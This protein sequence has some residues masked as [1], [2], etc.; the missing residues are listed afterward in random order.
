MSCAPSLAYTPAQSTEPG[1][2][3]APKQYPAGTIDPACPV[4]D[5]P[6]DCVQSAF[7]G[8][9][10]CVR[11]TAIV[12]CG[13][14]QQ[15]RTRHITQFPQLG[16]K[17]CP[18]PHM[19]E[20]QPC[21]QNP[22]TVEVDCAYSLWTAW[23]GCDSCKGQ[24]SRSRTITQHPSEKGKACNASVALG[25]T[26]Q[27]VSSRHCANEVHYCN[28]QSWEQWS[29]CKFVAADPDQCGTGHTKRKR[30]MVHSRTPPVAPV[31]PAARLYETDVSA[32]TDDAEDEEDDKDRRLSTLAFAFAAGGA[33][34]GLCMVVL[35]LNQRTSGV[36]R[37]QYE[38]VSS[39]V[40]Q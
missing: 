3:P 39:D 27:C 8:W 40:S 30:I 20:T 29:S 14:G 36:D 37:Q 6:I 34:V 22:C 2:D 4:G 16:G 23:N 18:D 11:G 9:S 7:S 17:E 13:G 10:A 1:G 19:A 38:S 24:N 15:L 31:A 12:T 5:D 35:R 25:E 33:S 32:I 26:Q 28:W 21:A